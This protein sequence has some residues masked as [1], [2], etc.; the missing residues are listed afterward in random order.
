MRLSLD[1]DL[2]TYHP[3]LLLLEARLP[4]MLEIFDPGAIRFRV[5]HI[6]DDSYQIVAVAGTGVSPMALDCLCFVAGRA[7]T[8]D[9]FENG[10]REPVAGYVASV[11]ES[12]R[13]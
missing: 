11:I 9:D 4:A 7:K 12:E 5:R 3:K 2:V 6:H 10:F 8:V 13:K 1:G